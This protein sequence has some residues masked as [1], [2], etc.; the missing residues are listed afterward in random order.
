[1]SLPNVVF[2]ELIDDEHDL[3]GTSG[4]YW[5]ERDD[6]TRWYVKPYDEPKLA[7]FDVMAARFYEAFGERVPEMLLARENNKLVSAAALVTNARPPSACELV[8]LSTGFLVDVWLNACEPVLE[9]HVPYSRDTFF[10][11][12][13]VN[14]VGLWRIDVGAIL[15]RSFRDYSGNF[16]PV[17]DDVW[18]NH[19]S[20]V[21]GDV[22]LA[23]EIELAYRHLK[24][25]EIA[26]QIDRLGAVMTDGVIDALLSDLGFNEQLLANTRTLLIYRRDQLIA[27]RHQFVARLR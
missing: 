17:P 5:V 26:A 25:E 14:D 10:A 7:Q 3:G 2:W 16:R 19:Y 11:N 21:S 13:L 4:G 24:A 27:S 18:E 9:Q 22:P 12:V 20:W 15:D 8:L 1:M 23:K 6:G